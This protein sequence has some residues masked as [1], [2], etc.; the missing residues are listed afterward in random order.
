MLVPKTRQE[1]QKARNIR[2]EIAYNG[3]PK[4]RLIVVKDGFVTFCQHLNY[5]GPWISFSLREDHDIVKRIASANA[6]M[7]A[8]SKIWDDDHVDTYSKYL[9]FRSI[10]CNLLL[11][12]CNIWTLRKS[13]LASLEVFLHMGIRIILKVKMC[14]VF[15]QRITNTSMREN[16][17]NIPTIKNQIVLC[18][19]TYLGK[20]FRQED[21]HIPTCLLTVWS[22]HPCKVGRPILTNKQCI[23]IN[24]QRVIPDVDVYGSVSTWVFHALDTQHWNDVLKTLKHPSF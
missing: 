7:G 10:P 5:L 22:D 6:L 11:W 17:Y 19:L 15:E 8:L 9:L 18:R 16:L 1:S 21:S 20:I 4:T 2:E 23:L 13:L 24:I 12:G 14:Q 3:L